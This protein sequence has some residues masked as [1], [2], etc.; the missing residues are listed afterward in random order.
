MET[1]EDQSDDVGGMEAEH[2]ATEPLDGNDQAANDAPMETADEQSGNVGGTEAEQEETER[3]DGNDQAANDAPMERAEDQSDNVGG[4]EAET[5]QHDGNNQAENMSPFPQDQPESEPD[6]VGPQPE[7]SG[8]EEDPDVHIQSE[9][10]NVSQVLSPPY[11][12]NI[13]DEKE[14][15][16]PVTKDNDEEEFVVLDAAHPL[17]A[18]TQA[19]L[20][21]QLIKELERLTRQLKEEGGIEKEEASQTQ[22]L[23]VELFRE[24]ERL[25]RLQTRLDGQQKTKA[26]AE[27]KHRQVQDELK[28]MKSC[29]SSTTNQCTMTRTNVSKL[30]TEL[31]KLKLHVHFTQEISEDLH[32]NVKATRNATRKVGTKKSKAE[33]QK[34]KQDMYAE[35]L[36]KELDRLT[37]QM[38]LYEVQT[39]AQAETT[40]AT[41]EALSEA[42]MQMESLAMA[43][44]QL[45]QQWNSSLLSMR[46]QDE[47]F[48]TMQEAVCMAG[49]Q[50]IVLDREIEGN[51]KS[52]SELQ[53]KSETLTMMLNCAQ[54]DCEVTKKMISQKQAQHETL[55]AQY[56]TY[57]RALGQTEC[58]LVELTKEDNGL[59]V[60]VTDQRQKLEKNKNKHLEL[61]NRIMTQ[62]LKKLMDSKAAQYYQRLTNKKASLKK[63]KIY[64][65]WHLES[66]VMAAALESNVINE[67]LENLSQTQKELDEEIR[68]YN[69][70]VASNQTNSSSIDAL[71]AQK[72]TTIANINKKI[73]LIAARTGHEDLSPLQIKVEAIKTQI[74]ALSQK[75]KNEQQLWLKHQGTLIGLTLEIQTHN[76]EYNKLQTKCTVICQ[77][78]IYLQRQLEVLHR[79]ES[80]VE[81][82]NK[83][84]QRDLLKLNTLLSKNAQLRHA[85]EQENAVMETEFLHKLKE[86]ERESLEMEAKLEKTQEEKEKLLSS[87]VEAE[88]Q[89]MLWE[90]KTH[91]MKETRLVV[92]EGQGEIQIMRDDVH[93]MERWLNLLIRQ[94]EQLLRDSI[95]VVERRGYII[96]R[97]DVMARS[98][99][100]T[101]T[102]GELN[103]MN[104]GLRR[105][106]KEIHKFVKEYDREIRELQEGQEEFQNKAKK[107]QE[108]ID[109]TP[110]TTASLEAALQGE[111][112]RVHT[113]RTIIHRVWVEMPKYQGSLWKVL[114]SLAEHA[115]SEEGDVNS[116]G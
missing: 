101:T 19:A 51:K 111:A 89:I 27:D 83:M 100:K 44:K 40:L 35:R 56:S 115:D 48:G 8:A 52:L 104:D 9:Q 5:E 28:A 29:H 3:Q 61:E 91:V 53:E 68:K 97:N 86:A 32:S 14:N 102:K 90:K 67:K 16:E 71:I 24:Q 34:L 80:E 23:Y 1:A 94:R 21:N 65:L 7:S 11:L 18:K 20:K 79:D 38:D 31:D 107:I 73:D 114:R 69:K 33:D 63:E 92:Q 96:E 64:Q 82:S 60:E 109:G 106:I 22:E 57:L 4:M 10:E 66:S 26:L 13:V 84:L 12:M 88:R 30:Q 58:T 78:K 39:N 98:T 112:E 55:Q 49:H 105:K 46:R 25:K 108:M 62:M 50:V 6:D 87:L 72:Q 45:L 37:Q 116:V 54:M 93:R 42:E 81:K 75:I 41:K 76:K 113:V 43:Q 95:A 110:S 85:L 99:N 77:K 74:D 15:E 47:E 70:V 103:L 2:E 36:T 17:V 59:Q